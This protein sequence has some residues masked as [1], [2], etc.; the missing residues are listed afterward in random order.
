M[1][2]SMEPAR[3][4]LRA[5]PGLARW[6]PL[7]V[8]ALALLGQWTLIANPGYFSHDELQ[9]AATAGEAGPI[10]WFSWGAIDAFQYRPLTFNLWMWLSRQLFAQP[11]AF[12]ALLVAW[13]AGN[14]ALLCV[15]ARRFGVAALPAAAGALVFA[16]G[17]FAS[18]VHGWVGTIGD[19]AWLGCALL[20]GLVATRWP[21]P[22]VAALAAAAF[23]AIGLLAKE[24]AA[25]IPALL[26]LAWWFDGRKRH[27]AA[28]TLASAAVVAAYLALRVGVLLHAPRDGGLYV[29]SA[30]HAPLRWLEYQLFAFVPNAFETFLTLSRGITSRIV[31]AGVLWL[32]LLAVLWRSRPRLAAIFLLG[33]I[34]ALAPVLPLG[35]SWN[36]YGYGYAAVTT[37]AVA[38]AW[39]RAPRW[40][41]GV[42]ALCALLCLWHGANVMRKMRHAGDVQAVFSPALAEAVAAHAARASGATPLRLRVAA[43]AEDDAWI[44][45]RLTHDIPSYRGI[46]IGRRV[47]LVAGD[48]PADAVI[49]AD[50]HIAPP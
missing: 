3:P 46:P 18:Y 10:P 15:L 37:M 40:G 32:A 36:H 11:Q 21:R 25:A 26:A 27:W 9:W 23:S 4:P 41:R 28:A 33:G 47:Q 34:A 30:A 12:H 45:E 38:A 17:P 16:L 39:P 20:A 42:I 48:A 8:F 43:E 24:A 31:V 35:S 22:A 13:G 6:S 2:I 19:L 44:F 5:R 7:L 29:V 14:A 1:A 49:T 50:G